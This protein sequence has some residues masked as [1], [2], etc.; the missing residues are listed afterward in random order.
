LKVLVIGGNGYL[1]RAYCEYL[2]DLGHESIVFDVLRDVRKIR[3][4]DIA[5]IHP[6]L[7]VNFSM[8]ANLKQA[9]ISHS[10]IDFQTNVEGL[11]RIIDAV[12]LSKVPLVQISTR[13]VI[14]LRDFRIEVGAPFTGSNDLRRVDENEPC[15][16]LHSYGKTKLIA[17]YLCQGYEYGSVI[18]LNTPYGDDWMSGRGLVSVLVKK[19]VIDARVRLDN[20]GRAVRD[21]LHINDLS[22]LIFKVVEKGCFQQVVNAGGGEQNVI[23]LLE[24]C[25]GVNPSVEVEFG[26]KNSDFGFLMDIGKASELGWFPRVNIRQWLETIKNNKP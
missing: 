25:Q 3:E 21:P 23:S 15:F 24:I 16:P 20:E 2:T 10:E 13:E 12:S 8:V 17:E 7:V 22:T 18:R 1:G 11:M 6:D 19:S 26:Q 9:H 14:G 5:E 4:R